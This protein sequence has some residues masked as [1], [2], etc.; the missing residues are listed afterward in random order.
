MVLFRDW[1]RSH[2]DDRDAYL[3]VKRDLAR[4]TWRHVAHYADS[5][6]AIVQEIMARATGT[7]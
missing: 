1:L 7:S 5:K 6:T 3:R 4:R 2:D